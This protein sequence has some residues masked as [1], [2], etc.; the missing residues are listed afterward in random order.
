MLLQIKR[1]FTYVCI[2][3]ASG[4]EN[5]ENCFSVRVCGNKAGTYLNFTRLF[6]HLLLQGSCELYLNSEIA[7]YSITDDT[8]VEL[9]SNSNYTLVCPVC[10][11][12]VSADIYYEIPNSIFFSIEDCSNSGTGCMCYY[13]NVHYIYSYNLHSA[14]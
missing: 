11:Q 8:C 1:L 13:N 6:N 10:N 3:L 9:S 5:C 4:G 12:N 7:H 2:L 14:T